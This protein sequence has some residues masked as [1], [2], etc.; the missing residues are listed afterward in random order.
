M[1]LFLEIISFENKLL[2]LLYTEHF[3][4]IIVNAHDTALREGITKSILQ[5]REIEL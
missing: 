2:N 3:I 5:M 1:S 4:Q